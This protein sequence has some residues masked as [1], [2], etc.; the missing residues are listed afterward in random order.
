MIIQVNTDHNIAGS[1]RLNEHV[2]EVITEAFGRHSE[3]IT[4]VEV[5]L[6]DENGN[7]SG[8]DDKK[9]VLEARMEGHQPVVATSHAGTTEQA[10]NLAIEKVKHSLDTI[11]GK[12]RHHDRSAKDALIDLQ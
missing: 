2:K 4:R 7:K 8:V 12:M 5:H 1:E 11:I 6:S 3:H 10:V 9:C